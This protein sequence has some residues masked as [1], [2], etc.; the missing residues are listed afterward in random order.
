MNVSLNLKWTQG[1]CGKRPYFLSDH[2]IGFTCGSHIKISRTDYFFETCIEGPVG[3]VQC[4]TADYAKKLLA[5]SDEARNNNIYIVDFETFQIL[6]QFNKNGYCKYSWIKFALKNYLYTLEAAPKFLLTLWNWEQGIKIKTISHELPV[7]DETRCLFSVHPLLK[8][9][10]CFLQ[11]DRL[12]F[13]E[14]DDLAE[15]QLQNI[16][17]YLPL[18]GD[19]E[20]LTLLWCWELGKLRWFDKMNHDTW[21]NHSELLHSLPLKACCKD[22]SD[23]EIV[24]FF[25]YLQKTVRSHCSCHCWL[26]ES[27]LLLASMGGSVFHINFSQKK[28]K[29]LYFSELTENKYHACTITSISV[30]INGLYAAKYNG[31]FIFIPDYLKEWKETKMF[32][33]VH[34]PLFMTFS[35]DFTDIII[36]TEKDEL[37]AHNLLDNSLCCLQ[38][39]IDNHTVVGVYVPNEL[40]VITAKASGKIETWNIA[41]GIQHSETNINHNVTTM[42]GSILVPI[43]LVAT[44]NS[45]LY[46]M[47]AS[48]SGILR[49][50]EILRP[51]EKPI[52]QI[53]IQNYGKLALLLTSN[54]KLFFLNL[55]PTKHFNMLGYIIL[56]HEILDMALFS[57]GLYDM[58]Y[59]VLLCWSKRGNEKSNC[60]LTF[61]LPEDFDENFNDYWKDKSGMLDVD[62]LKQKE[63]AIDHISSSITVHR[64]F[65][66]FLTIVSEKKVLNIPETLDNAFTTSVSEKSCNVPFDLD[67]SSL[68]ISPSN[69]IILTVNC[70]GKM[71]L[72]VVNDPDTRYIFDISTYTT[73]NE[74]PFIKFS[75]KEDALIIGSSS[76]DV[77]CYTLPSLMRENLNDVLSKCEK[78]MS[79]EK[80]QLLGMEA[81]MKGDQEMIP[82]ETLMVNKLNEETLKILEVKRITVYQR[83]LLLS[84]ELET[85]TK[86]NSLLLE[87]YQWGN[88]EFVTDDKLREDLVKERE[89]NVTHHKEYLL[90]K[91]N[92]EL[93]FIDNMKQECVDNMLERGNILQSLSN[94]RSLYNYSIPHIPEHIKLQIQRAFKVF[95]VEKCLRHLILGNKNIEIQ[96][97]LNFDSLDSD[98][99]KEEI[100]TEMREEIFLMQTQK[101]RINY[102]YI[103]EY[104]IFR[105]RL[106]FNKY[107]QKLLKRKKETVNKVKANDI[108]IREIATVIGEQREIWEIDEVTES[109]ETKLRPTEEE[110]N[111]NSHLKSEE[112]SK[113][114]KGIAGYFL[115]EEWLQTLLNPIVTEVH[116]KMKKLKRDTIS[117]M[118]KEMDKLLKNSFEALS[119]YET[120]HERVIDEKLEWDLN[121]LHDELQLLLLIFC[122]S[123]RKLMINE[124]SFLIENINNL[125]ME[126][127][128]FESRKASIEAL[129]SRM[130][131]VRE[132]L[133]KEVSVID[134]EVFNLSKL[135]RNKLAFLEAYAKRPDRKPVS[136]TLNPFEDLIMLEFRDFQKINSLKYKP[137]RVPINIWRDLCSHREQ[138]AAIE[139]RLDHVNT[140]YNKFSL[141]KLE[142]KRVVNNI[143]ASILVESVFSRCMNEKIVESII[144]LPIVIFGNSSQLEVEFE[145]KLGITSWIFLK[146]HHI[147][148]LNN[149]IRIEGEHNLQ[150][151]MRKEK[152]ENQIKRNSFKLK[153]IILEQR[154][155]R[156]D[157][158]TI[159][160][161]PMGREVQNAIQ[162]PKGFGPHVKINELEKSHEQEKSEIQRHIQ[163]ILYNITHTKNRMEN[164]RR[165]MNQRL[166][167]I[168]KLKGNLHELSK[169]GDKK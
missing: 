85:L 68:I 36:L 33:I 32:S 93:K 154:D 17:I 75:A 57:T 55:L 158:E 50:I 126:L 111:E 104:I 6:S 48:V 134:S 7:I 9:I 151:L 94:G 41:N 30:N 27:N 150:A 157:I 123:N 106:A 23:I 108:Q 95:Q 24:R 164:L 46:I 1:K 11:V 84:E 131:K 110:I 169:L 49:I 21:G 4:F 144:E 90:D 56:F 159:L 51:S 101:E 148:A 139:E 88:E 89:E 100:C 15:I 118:Q 35:P 124:D 53:F 128:I 78:L 34:S 152:A 67:K 156:I 163:N 120:Y 80:R 37:L 18:S 112:E 143:R 65:G 122:T 86:E 125:K 72:W 91:L 161:L 149:L 31:D 28:V 92:T 102:T 19:K 87:E 153:C 147:K 137:L 60:I 61:E 141:K 8:N 74:I 165:G 25:D 12:H 20:G 129:L 2:E 76:G 99:I 66:I 142:I 115:E 103:L 145:N 167:E 132:S 107:F 96:E 162:D 63:I 130:E 98:E 45:Y 5:F 82:W 71:C 117:R 58:N 42:D 116:Q 54:N 140:D 22:M 79:V 73:S 155:L 43:F 166:K 26:P 10:A 97:G 70:E 29:V 16:T 39:G 40:Y 3:G 168:E 38:I 69:N 121:I 133:N 160:N 136:E 135:S 114:S 62:I 119:Y 105:K 44:C 146:K 83:M 77:S 113:I 14:I 52:I 81:K 47:D 109:L 138:K 127:K 59:V 13:Y 64:H